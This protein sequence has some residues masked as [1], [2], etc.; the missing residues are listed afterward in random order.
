MGES[1]SRRRH[2]DIF[3]G[4]VRLQDSDENVKTIPL[5]INLSGEFF[6]EEYQK[7]F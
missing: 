1:H 5:Q 6:D 7:Y 3:L 2:L 4:R